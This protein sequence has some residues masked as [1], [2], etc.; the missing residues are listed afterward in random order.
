MEY[1]FFDVP[2]LGGGLL[3]GIVAIV[4]IFVSHF[5]VGGGLYL[6][7]TEKKAYRENNNRILDYVKS[8]TRFFVLLTLV[9][10]AV[11]GVGIWFTIALVH[12]E[13]TSTLIHAFVW[14]WAIEWVF[15]VVEIA[16]AFVYYYSWKRLS[17]KNHVIVGWIYFVAAWAS[18]AVING[19]LT[20]ML[21]P[22]AWLQTQNFWQGV[23]NPTYFSSL[24]IRTAVAINLA[25]LYGL[26]TASMIK[27]DAETRATLIRYNT[28]WLFTG[29]AAL[30]FLGLWYISQIP[31]LARFISM[32]GAAAVTLFATATIF[33]SG[34]I[35]LFAWLSPWKR[36]KEFTTT[37][38]VMFMVLGFIVTGVTEW[39]R[40][41]V[42]KPFVI[43]DYMYSNGF[44]AEDATLYNSEGIL[45]HAKW[46]TVKEATFDNRLQAGE[47]VFRMQCA[48][49]HVVDGYNAVKPMVYGWDKEYTVDQLRRLH[50]LKP[51]M[52][53]VFGTQEEKEALAEWLVSLNA[54]EMAQEVSR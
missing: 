45:P 29:F 18:L 14:G 1:P 33:F 34:L 11:T 9:F 19:I 46:S 31:P 21:T 51:F 10:G 53:P 32:G 37:F 54:N 12:P 30:P 8:H 17:R 25:G 44:K 6:V 36:P 4:H 48:H 13:A 20:F 22:G 2:L 3:I 39:T 35:L 24:L 43:Y 7:L 23:L 52:P 41:A 38:A 47:Q 49:C 26:L 40:E 5:A 42:R 27:D 16:A 15:F 50:I 28:K